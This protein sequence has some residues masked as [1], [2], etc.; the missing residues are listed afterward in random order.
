VQDGNIITSKG[1]GTAL[2]FA[3]KISENLAG[4]DMAAAIAEQVLF[5]G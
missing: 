2:S 3:L 4:K 1:A 5:K